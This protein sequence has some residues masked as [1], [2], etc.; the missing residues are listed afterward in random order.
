MLTNCIHRL[1]KPQRQRDLQWFAESLEMARAW[2]PPS[3]PAAGGLCNSAH[4]E[5]DLQVANTP[6]KP[7]LRFLEMDEVFPG[8][9]VLFGCHWKGDVL[10]SCTM[11]N[12]VCLLPRVQWESQ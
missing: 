6:A 8:F 5:G 1:K 12:A 4:T 3:L 7:S 9:K 10:Y 2:K 11:T